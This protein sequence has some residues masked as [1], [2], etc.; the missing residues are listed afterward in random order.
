M[1]DGLSF[2]EVTFKHEVR[3]RVTHEAAQGFLEVN[4][5]RIEYCETAGIVRFYSDE[6]DL[7]AVAFDTLHWYIMAP[8]DNEPMGFNKNPKAH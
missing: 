4:T 2:R 8:P 1:S 5:K 7:L 6:G 3:I